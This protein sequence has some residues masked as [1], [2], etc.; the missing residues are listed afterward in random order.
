[1]QNESSISE[2]NDVTP[3]RFSSL[4]F[5]L[6]RFFF[7]CRFLFFWF[8]RT[9]IFKLMPLFIVVEYISHLLLVLQLSKPMVVTKAP[10]LGITEIF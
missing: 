5:Q 4:L 7:F 8:M 3:I 2:I 1:M 9:G 6:I 10:T